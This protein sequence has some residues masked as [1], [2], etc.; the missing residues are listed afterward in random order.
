ML[1]NSKLVIGVLALAGLGVPFYLLTGR[2]CSLLRANELQKISLNVSET[3]L[4]C[5]ENGRNYS[6]YLAPAENSKSN[7]QEISFKV[8]DNN[9]EK[10][11]KWGQESQRGDE[12]D[13]WGIAI[14]KNG[15]EKGKETKIRVPARN[16]YNKEKV[17]ITCQKSKLKFK[18]ESKACSGGS[19]LMNTKLKFDIDSLGNVKIQSANFD[20]ADDF[21]PNRQFCNY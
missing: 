12:W 17:L 10:K 18:D 4:E 20:W 5:A 2:K 9:S 19:I 13:E 7:Q 15:T 3:V 16:V 6:I 1:V 21:K 11:V 8:V 14:Y